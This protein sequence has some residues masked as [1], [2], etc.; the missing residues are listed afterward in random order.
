MQ[1]RVV[2]GAGVAAVFLI[3]IAVYFL[4]NM[5]SQNFEVSGVQETENSYV[6]A[7]PKKSPHY[8][9]NVPEH[10]AVLAGVPVNV[11]INFN[12][13]VAAGSEITINKNGRDYGTR[14]TIIDSNK[15]ALRREMASDAPEGSYTVDYKACWPDGSCHDGY[16]QFAINR[17]LANS[18][19][20][21]TGMDEIE[22]KMLSFAFDKDNIIISKGTKITWINEDAAGHY[23]NADPHPGHNYYPA[24]NSNLL[25]KGQSFSLTFDKPGIYPYHCSA[26]Y[27][28][29]KGMILVV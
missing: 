27:A 11:V 12:F 4:T 9:T 25:A 13:D 24:Q 18:F 8:E 2:L 23:V 26:H 20:D 1:K 16:F 17:T 6:F 14:D 21:L 10:R 29:M 19:E 15:L 3:G 7:A 28:G 5:S 22:V